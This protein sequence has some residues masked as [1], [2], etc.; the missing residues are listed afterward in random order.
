MS[1]V[2]SRY[3]RLI[4]SYFPRPGIVTSTNCLPGTGTGCTSSGYNVLAPA[5][6]TS[7][8]SDGSSPTVSSWYG[9]RYGTWTRNPFDATNG[10]CP[11][12]VNLICPR[13]TTQKI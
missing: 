7:S 8:R 1:V 13:S 2:K 3:G 6:E 9:V 10:G 11:S 4:S 5:T 12:I